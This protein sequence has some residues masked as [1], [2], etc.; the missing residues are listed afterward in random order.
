MRRLVEARMSSKA[1]IT[2]HEAWMYSTRGEV[3][4]RVCRQTIRIIG[5]EADLPTPLPSCQ[6]SW[7]PR[8]I[9]PRLIGESFGRFDSLSLGNEREDQ[10]QLS[11]VQ[12]V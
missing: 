2:E 1:Q 6:R 11:G 3:W 5:G 9:A 8:E 10:A 4:R 7:H 12:R